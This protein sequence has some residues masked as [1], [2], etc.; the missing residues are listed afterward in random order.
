MSPDKPA[1]FQQYISLLNEYV[2]SHDEA[3]LEKIEAMG[4]KMVQSNVP[5]EDIGEM[6][7]LAIAGQLSSSELSVERV[8]SASLPLL[9]LLISYGMESRAIKARKEKADELVR[10]LSQ[11]IEQAGESILITDREGIIEYVNPAF[12]KL[13]GYTAEE[14]IGQTPRLLN[15]GRQDAAFYEEMWGTIT[16]GKTWH[17]KIFDR[18]KDASVYPAML[19]IS[20]IL[21]GS[22]D[23]THYISFVGIQSDL[24][25]FENMERQ[26][27]QAQKMEA[28]GT[29]VGGIAHDFNNMLSGMIG[30]LYLAKKELKG[31]PGVL[32]KLANVEQLS[33]R[34]SEMI[35]QLL[36]F[37]RR[38]S[39]DIKPLPLTPF[40]KQALKLLRTSVP[41]NIDT[42]L[43]I[44]NDAL[45]I[46]GDGTQIHQTLMNLITNARDAVE[47]VDDPRIIVRLEPFQPSEAF[48]ERREYF[49][50][51]RYAHLSVEDNGHGIPEDKV[52]HVF[53]PF[54]TTKEVGKGTGLG[55]AMVYGAVKTHHGFVEVES[56]EG[57]G[58]TFHIYLPLLVSEGVAAASVKKEAVA[59]GQ[60]ETILL[61]DDEPH[62]R[63]AFAEVLE[64][65][66][67]KVLTAKDGV[68]ALEAFNTHQQDIALVMLDVVMP[69]CGG[70]LLA[71]RIRK[72]NPDVPVIF[73]TGYDKEHVLGSGEQIQNSDAISKPFQV[74]VLSHS[75]RKLLD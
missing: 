53:E 16:S 49:K 23:V 60:G 39:V 32:Q 45:T 62:V 10:K 75:I 58:S 63:E 70:T 65:L 46:H 5:L 2:D 48:L 29:L 9:Q 24:T 17:G 47:G 44:C 43:D 73:V 27:H 34:A 64:S 28:L 8:K 69:H 30:N 50:V 74:D 37:A 6:H 31:A 7:D 1:Y 40:I 61:A 13:T 11:A 54:F 41:E 72:V 36:T 14:A 33:F 18:K 25:E 38:G 52:E 66:G 19:T 35:Q 68:G 56:I 71:K 4:R 21:D 3:P 67:Y 55:L 57:K 42:R 12:T 22:G 26:F 51:G 59:L 15:S 20:P